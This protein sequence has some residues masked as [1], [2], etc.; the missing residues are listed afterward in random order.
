M[1]AEIKIL[2]HD[3]CNYMPRTV[4]SEC[5]KFVDQYADLVI[6][7]LAQTMDPKSVCT[8]I[9]LCKP[10]RSMISGR[11]YCWYKFVYQRTE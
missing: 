3:I 9:K 1:Q 8:E 10:T 5:N 6:T 7:L 11:K 4:A 2:V